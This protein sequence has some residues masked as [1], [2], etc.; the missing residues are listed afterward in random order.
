MHFTKSFNV[1]VLSEG[2]VLVILSSCPSVGTPTLGTHLDDLSFIK[3]LIYLS[4][5]HKA[6]PGIEEAHWMQTSAF[7]KYQHKALFTKRKATT[8]V[9]VCHIQFSGIHEIFILW[10]QCNTQY[11]KPTLQVQVKV[12]YQCVHT[13]VAFV[14]LE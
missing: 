1:S 8:C 5:F 4:T 12:R 11:S 7:K 14:S 10:S 9:V 6:I 2:R 13:A 3:R